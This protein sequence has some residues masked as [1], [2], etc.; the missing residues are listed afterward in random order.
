MTFLHSGKETRVTWKYG[1][2]EVDSANKST[3]TA[4]EPNKLLAV[5][6]PFAMFKQAISQYVLFI[7]K[8]VNDL[9]TN[10]LAV[11]FFGLMCPFS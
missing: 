11:I 10:L 7:S 3:E 8:S 5:S 1:K 2:K 9:N 6:M 4:E